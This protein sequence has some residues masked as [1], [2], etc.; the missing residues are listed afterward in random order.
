MKTARTLCTSNDVIV[1]E[2]LNVRGL[3]KKATIFV[4]DFV[5]DELSLLIEPISPVRKQRQ[6][7]DV[8]N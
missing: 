5:L 3:V 4:P 8:R 6:A 2:N 1:L 7:D